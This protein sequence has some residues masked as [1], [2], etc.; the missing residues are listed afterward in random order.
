MNEWDDSAARRVAAQARYTEVMTTPAPE[1]TSAYADA[2]VIGFVFGEMWRRGVL[3]ER[4]R[5]W[6]TL[7]CCDVSDA[8][9][10]IEMHAWAALNSGDISPEEY[11]EYLLFFATQAGWPKGSAV[12]L[13]GIKAMHRL[14]EEHD[15]APRPLDFEPWVEPTSDDARRERGRAA[16]EDIHGAAAPPAETVF[17]GRGYLDFLYG[18]IW[19]RERHLTRRDRRI[20]AICCAGALRVDEEAREHLRAALATGDL[21]Y[22]ELQELVLHYA[23]YVGWLLGRHLDSLL[24]DAADELGERT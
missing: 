14:A 1:S 3:S 6:I 20:I 22:A 4:D 23:V 5:R 24:I 7:A 12:A 11:D 10:P 17:G 19:T 13:S 2:G 16:Y 21:T 9:D 18:E 15:A 8:V